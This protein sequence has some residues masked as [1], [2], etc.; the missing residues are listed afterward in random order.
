MNRL[1]NR[2]EK[3]EQRTGGGVF[4]IVGKDAA[5]CENKLALHKAQNPDDYRELITVISG[6]DG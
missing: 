6:Y 4:Y 5:D 2:V 1:E 3:L